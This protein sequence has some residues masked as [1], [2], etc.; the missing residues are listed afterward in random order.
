LLV[1]WRKRDLKVADRIGSMQGNG[2]R[3]DEFAAYASARAISTA[4][5]FAAGQARS[6]ELSASR[7]DVELGRASE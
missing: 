3:A 7:V 6:G 5:P 2:C 1:R 4:A